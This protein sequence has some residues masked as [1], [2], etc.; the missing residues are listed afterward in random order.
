MS[1]PMF[2]RSRKPNLTSVSVRD[3]EKQLKNTFTSRR[4][5]VSHVP[6]VAQ[7]PDFDAQEEGSILSS[8]VVVAGLSPFPNLEPG[9]S[10]QET[11]AW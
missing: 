5:A 10:A 1:I 2:L 8:P 9:P 11:V 7:R 6:V 3:G 4:G